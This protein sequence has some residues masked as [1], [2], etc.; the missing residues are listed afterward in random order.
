LAPPAG[1]VFLIVAL[2]ISKLGVR[3]YTSVGS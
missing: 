2:Q 1:M 3:R